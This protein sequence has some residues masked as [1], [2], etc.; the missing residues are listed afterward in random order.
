MRTFSLLVMIIKSK[1]RARK[2]HSSS[3]FYTLKCTMGDL[4]EGKVYSQSDIESM[5]FKVTLYN[6]Q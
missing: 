4:I 6:S 5:R 2:I 1:V 3:V